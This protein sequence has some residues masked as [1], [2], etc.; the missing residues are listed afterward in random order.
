MMDRRVVG[1]VTADEGEAVDAG[2]L[3][4]ALPPHFHLEAF[5]AGMCFDHIALAPIAADSPVIVGD[6]AH[7]FAD[8][9]LLETIKRVGSRDFAITLFNASQSYAAGLRKF[10]DAL[11]SIVPRG[12]PRPAWFAQLQRNVVAR[13][14]FLR[15]FGALDSED[16]AELAGSQAENRRATAH[17][18]QEQQQIFSV[19]HMG[20]AFFPG[21]QF[22]P[23][24]GRPKPAVHPVLS[25]LPSSLKGWQL[26]MWWATPSDLLNWGRPVD[27]LEET[28]D[29]VVAAARA[30]E[31]EWKAAS[32]E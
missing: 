10:E 19:S 22:D 32:G 2:A 4:Q 13:D 8:E 14:E 3:D 31:A 24:T 1:F 5:L 29:A 25:A 12:V 18:W 21:F 20:R 26:A 6:A 28:P 23:D 17:R 15:E 7:A 16:V 11:S 30:E 9:S 27:L